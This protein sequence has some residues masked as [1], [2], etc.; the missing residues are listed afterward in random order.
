MNS[1]NGAETAVDIEDTVARIRVFGEEG[2]CV[3]YLIGGPKTT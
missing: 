1:L 2:G 3:G